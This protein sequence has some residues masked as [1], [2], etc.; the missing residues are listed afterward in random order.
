MPVGSDVKKFLKKFQK[1]VDKW[2]RMCYNIKRR[3]EKDKN[4]NPEDVTEA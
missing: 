2:N 3:R 1:T 4:P